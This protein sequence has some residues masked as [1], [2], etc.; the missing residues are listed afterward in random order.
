MQLHFYHKARVLLSIVFIGW[1][2]ISCDSSWIISKERNNLGE[3]ATLRK[4]FF[5]G[6]DYIYL[7]TKKQNKTVEKL[8]Y[9]CNCGEYHNFF[10]KE[11]WYKG[12]IEAYYWAIKDTIQ[13]SNFFD[14]IPR[15]RLTSP[16]VFVHIT[17]EEKDFL[18]R[19]LLKSNRDC[20]INS[21]DSLALI[22][23]FVKIK[24]E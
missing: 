21:C 6:I 11:V 9:D 10:R 2:L 19:G 24:I 15:N 12:K 20:C 16:I 4:G 1:I 17:N 7:D 23:G 13:T 3:I 8:F 5:H 14:D 18:K 22:K